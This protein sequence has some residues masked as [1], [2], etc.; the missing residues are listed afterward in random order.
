MIFGPDGVANKDQDYE[1]GFISERRPSQTYLAAIE[2]MSRGVL[3]ELLDLP[4]YSLSPDQ[5]KI[6]Y[7]RQSVK[8]KSVANNA[9][10]ILRSVWNWA[11]LMHTDSE[12]FVRNPVSLAMRQ[13]GV[14]INKTNRR[15]SRLFDEDFG[16]YLKAVLKLNQ[17]DH[18]SAFRNGRDSLLFMLFSGVRLTGTI[19]I[20]INNI[21][22][23]RKVFTIIKKGGDEACLPLNTVTEALVRNRLKNL[24][25]NIE[26]LFSRINGLGH[27]SGTRA[28]RRNI[29]EL[30]G[31]SMT[32]HDLRRTYKTIG[33]ELNMN[34][35]IIDELLCHSREGV[36]A[37]YIHPSMESLRTGSQ[38]IADY[39][40]AKSRVDVVSELSLSW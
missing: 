31:I 15:N 8:G 38:Q 25:E 27:Y 16:N 21:D 11:Q 32:N 17:Y 10:R 26:Y 13:L 9:M 3:S 36:D 35:T 34:S 24:P 39:I 5:V 18:T 30:C 20:K 19:T 33:A 7:L 12:L 2:K 6:V 23:E 40:L 22:M 37:H 29:S 28:S 4:L 1:I 14:N